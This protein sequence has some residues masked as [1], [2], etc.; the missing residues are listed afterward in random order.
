MVEL[1]NLTKS[2]D[3]KII[4]DNFS[5]TFADTGL[6]AVVGESGRGKTTLLRII[7]HLE[8]SKKES[9]KSPKKIA[10]SF[11]EYRL[12]DQLDVYS[13][14]ESVAFRKPSEN[15][16]SLILSYL[17]RLGLSYCAASYPSELSGGMRQRVSLIRAFVCDASVVLLDEPF[18]ELDPELIHT[19]VEI[20]QELSQKKLVIYTSHSEEDALRIGAQ[21]VKL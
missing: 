12:F 13:N 14:I 5:Y 19:V 16:K 21:I 9:V 11:Q 15:D 20:I 7:A 3:E 1:K 4:F 17:K 18:K 10:F 8:D 2:Y 6:Y